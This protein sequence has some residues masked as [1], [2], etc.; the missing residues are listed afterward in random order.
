MEEQ[1]VFWWSHV[2][3]SSSTVYK[4]ENSFPPDF[5]KL[6]LYFQDAQ[7]ESLIVADKIAADLNPFWLTLTR[8]IKRFSPRLS[9]K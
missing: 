7:D 8:F 4:T 9:R 6:T 5:N 3:N 2:L 1:P